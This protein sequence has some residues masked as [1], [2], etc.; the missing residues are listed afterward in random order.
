MLLHNKTAVVYGAGGSVGGAVAQGFAREGAQLVLVGR[1][2]E[3]LEAVAAVIMDAGGKAECAVLDATDKGQVEAHATAVAAKQGRIDISFNAVGLDDTQGEP[4]ALM[5]TGRFF[6]PIT[7]ALRTQLF[8]ALAVARHMRGV[9]VILGITANCGRQPFP[10]TGG[11]GVACA[12][13]E[14]LYRQLA[15]ELGPSGIRVVCLMS[16]GSPDSIGV[17]EVFDMHSENAGVSREEWDRR[18]GEGTMLRHLPSLAEVAGAAVIMASDY[19]RGMTGTIANVT[20]GQ[21]AD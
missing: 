4:L 11:F 5:D 7:T 8:T 10:N 6:A 2:L 1:T 19:A 15:T 18:A 20:C 3:T 21:L 17:S 13:V 9:G 12:A 16:A 14:G